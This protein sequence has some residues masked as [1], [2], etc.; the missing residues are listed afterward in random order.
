MVF[1]LAY[2]T[3]FTLSPTKILIHTT[4][5][6]IPFLHHYTTS[7]FLYFCCLKTQFHKGLTQPMLTIKSCYQFTALKKQCQQHNIMYTRYARPFIHSTSSQ[8]VLPH[9]IVKD[10]L[11]ETPLKSTKQKPCILYIRKNLNL[12]LMINDQHQITVGHKQKEIFRAT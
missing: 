6:L 8:A 4:L 5:L 1:K 9:K 11:Q 7:T 3:F 2:T 10:V 12:G